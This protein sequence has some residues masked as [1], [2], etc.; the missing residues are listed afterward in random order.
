MYTLM[1]SISPAP[2]ALGATLKGKNLLPSFKSNPQ[3]WSD[4]VNTVK[5][6]NQKMI[7]FDLSEGME[8]CKMSG[9][10]QGILKWMIS[11]NPAILIAVE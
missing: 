8:N 7:F 2:S 1:R 9:K 4:T 5:V 3:I 6:K 11:G 10:N